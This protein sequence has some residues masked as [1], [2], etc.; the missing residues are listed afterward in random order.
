MQMLEII[1]VVLIIKTD[2]EVHIIFPGLC[3][4]LRVWHSSQI[5]PNK[6]FCNTATPIL[7]QIVSG[8]FHTT[9]AELSSFN[10]NCM[11]HKV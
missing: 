4:L 1:S 2:Y 5:Q 7:V 8:C 11:A 3:W 9:M 10:R 6:C